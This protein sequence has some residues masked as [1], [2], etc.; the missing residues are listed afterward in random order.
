LKYFSCGKIAY[1]ALWCLERVS[2]YK[3]KYEKK[4]YYI[5]DE[6]VIDEESG[7]DD[8]WVFISIK[9]GDSKP[10]DSTSFMNV[11]KALAAQI[12]ERD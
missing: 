11:E 2:K 12:E 5:V 3:P 1:Y 7:K 4:C 6:G 9:E 8:Q 10:I